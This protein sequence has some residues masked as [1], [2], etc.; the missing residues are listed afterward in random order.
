MSEGYV[1][2]YALG[3]LGQD[4]ELK[5]G[6]TGTAVLNFTLACNSKFADKSGEAKEK[7][8]WL[9][10][11]VFDKQAEG[12]ASYLKKGQCINIKGTL[13]TSTS[14]KDGV[15][16]YSTTV[17]VRQVFFAGGGQRNDSEPRQQTRAAPKAAKPG[18]TTNAAADIPF[19]GGG[20][21]DDLPF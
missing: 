9:K 1:D 21:N 17:I 2:V 16:T 3:N 15:K 18:P 5:Y 10:C 8:E 19:G 6:Q 11:V 7:T 4:A 20:E 12:L 13:D 14:D